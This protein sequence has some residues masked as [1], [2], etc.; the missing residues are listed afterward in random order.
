MLR[1]QADIFAVLLYYCLVQASV[2]AVFVAHLHCPAYLRSAVSQLQWSQK[3]VYI[4]LMATSKFTFLNQ[5][6]NI[7]FQIIAELTQLAIF[8]FRVT[9]RMNILLRNFL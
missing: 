9:V 8:L 2:A 5:W 4:L 7:L 1:G 3:C 6:N